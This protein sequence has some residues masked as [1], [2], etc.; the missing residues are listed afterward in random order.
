MLMLKEIFDFDLI[1]KFF[2]TNTDFKVLFDALSGVTGPYGKAIFEEE[3]GLSN[4]TQNCIPSPDFNGGHPD[5]NLT[6]AHSLVE[7]VDKNNIHF[8]AASDGDGDRNMIYGAN[9]FVSP[10]DSLAIIAHHAKLIPYFKK[11]GVYGLARSMPTSGAV[12][13]VPTGWKFFC[14]LFD[15]DKLS[16]CGEESFGTGSNH[17]REKDGLWAVVAWLN[18]IAGIGEANPGVTPSIA[19]IQH[20]FWTIYGRTFFTR[21]D[22]ENVDSDG[23]AKIV[24]ELTSKI[25]DKSF[26]GSKV[27]GKLQF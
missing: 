17:I 8:G 1:K 22:Y 10:G 18:I 20:D 27:E 6:Y 16:I 7:A 3:L 9:A 13:L 24:A 25:Q 23:A 19:K 12:D 2:K 14:A 15:A 5:P 21:Y 26:I 4:S 11:Q